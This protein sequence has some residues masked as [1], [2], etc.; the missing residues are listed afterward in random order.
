MIETYDWCRL[1][2]RRLG[3]TDNWDQFLSNPFLSDIFGKPKCL[4]YKEYRY[5][6]KAEVLYNQ[7]GMPEET[8]LPTRWKEGKWYLVEFTYRPKVKAEK[9]LDY[10]QGMD[11]TVQPDSS[12]SVIYLCVGDYS[13]GVLD[14]DK[15][16]YRFFIPEDWI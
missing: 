14:S 5:N 15:Y 4:A 16:E 13:R 3:I 2:L 6:G 1:G 9:V 11:D 10:D 7:I 8:I 12:G